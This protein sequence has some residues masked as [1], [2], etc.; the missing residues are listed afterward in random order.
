MNNHINAKT[1]RS[2][3]AGIFNSL[4][5]DYALDKFSSLSS[6][7]GGEGWGEE[8][9]MDSYLMPLTP[10]L[11]PFGRGEGVAAA[12]LMDTWQRHDPALFPL[13]VLAA[14]RLGVEFP[15]NHFTNNTHH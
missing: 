7:K 4:F 11:S 5:C 9:K 6:L 13:C 10:A 14:S 8:A 1:R 2:K 3:G 12:A 15:S